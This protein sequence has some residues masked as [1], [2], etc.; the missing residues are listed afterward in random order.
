VDRN[1]KKQ[2]VASL[3]DIFS[4]TGL[5]VVTHYSGLTVAELTAL[6]SKMRAAGASFKV[7]KNRLTRLALKDTA[8]ESLESL[9]KGPTA[10]ACSKDPVAA[11]KVAVEYAKANEK[12]VVLGGALGTMVLGVDGVKA[13]ATLPSLDEL[14]AKIVG[15]VS[16][17][18]TRIAGVLQAPAGQ[19]ARVLKAKAE[20]GAAA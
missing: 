11:A 15:M 19:L 9:F 17:P 18:A 16:T 3:H 20:Q 13:L 10:V 12:L 5:V 6:R 2:L 1:Q 14:R 8:Y 7:T 4:D